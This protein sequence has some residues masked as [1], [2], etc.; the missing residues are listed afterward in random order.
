MLVESLRC[1]CGSVRA[2]ALLWVTLES[3]FM[4]VLMCV[5][6]FIVCQ[7]SAERVFDLACAFVWWQTFVRERA[8]APSDALSFAC[9]CV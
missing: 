6:V 7:V 8:G 2:C 3:T 9:V 4:H 5:C 1:F